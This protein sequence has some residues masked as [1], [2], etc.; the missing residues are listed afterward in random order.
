M[1][2]ASLP[3]RSISA[4]FVLNMQATDHCYSLPF[5]PKT[6]QRRNLHGNQFYII[7]ADGQTDDRRHE[8][9][10]KINQKSSVSSNR[11]EALRLSEN[12]WLLIDCYINKLNVLSSRYGMSIYL[13]FIRMQ[14][15]ALK[16]V[17]VFRSEGNG[18]E[19]EIVNCGT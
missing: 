11:L 3:Y 1:V 4:W 14:R 8:Q 16:Q 9:N 19:K 13:L 5:S 15:T 6:P 12:T 2:S 7:S 18:A 17:T 10:Q